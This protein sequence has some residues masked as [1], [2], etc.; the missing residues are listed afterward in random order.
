MSQETIVRL[1]AVV[2]AVAGV[3]VLLRSTAWGF[4]ARD[5]LIMQAG[6]LSGDQLAIA[7]TAPVTAYRTLG[8]ILV[9]VG[10]FQAL[11]PPRDR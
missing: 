7:T 3:V 2:L 5:R 9:G 6:G 8:A 1:I 4:Q 11:T 10:L